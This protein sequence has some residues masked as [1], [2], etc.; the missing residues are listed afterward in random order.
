M[1]AYVNYTMLQREMLAVTP[2]I[3]L[4]VRVCM[5]ICVCIYS[6]V[7]ICMYLFV[8]IH[9]YWYVCTYMHIYKSV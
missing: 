8:C 4:N 9:V 5:Y 3:Y 7:Y 6:C 2:G 1:Y